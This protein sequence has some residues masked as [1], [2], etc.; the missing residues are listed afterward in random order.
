MPKE[1][2]RSK[3]RDKPKEKKERSGD[4]D[5]KTVEDIQGMVT[6]WASI[7]FAI[8]VVLCAGSSLNLSAY[9][10]DLKDKLG[11]EPIHQ[12][13]IKWGVLFGYYGGILAGPMVDAFNT[14]PS[15]VLSAFVSCGGY[16]GLGF[17][18]ASDKVNTVNTIVI[19]SLIILVAFTSAVA[20][21]SAIA[22]VIKNFSRNVGSMIASIMITYYLV[23]PW[24]DFTI[25]HGY[26]EDVEVKVNMIAMGVITFVVYIL[27]SFI[28]DENEQS[29]LLKKASAITDRIG[30]L[31]YAAI[32][33]GFV[34]V[35]YLTCI[36]AEK[37]K[38]GVFL[39]ALF[40]LINFIALAF[41]ISAL[42]GQIGRGGTRNVDDEKLPPRKN[43]I[44]MFGDIR[45]YCLL[46]GTFIVVGTGTAFYVEAADLAV[47]MGKTP[48]LGAKV[49]KAY[50]LS[51]CATALGGGLIAA[52]FVRI[53][54]GWLFAAAAAFTGMVGFGMVF[55]GD[56]ADIWF[57]IAGFLIGGAVGGWWVI[58]PQIILDDAGPKSYE[59]LWG[60][61]LT[62]N[63]LGM[64]AFD[65]FF[66]LI[67]GKEEAGSPSSCK[68]TSC[69]MA[70]YL[71]F[72]GL[73]MIAGVLALVG[74]SNDE[75]TGGAGGE[76][77][78][79]RN[80]DA[81]SRKGR[82]SSK[83]TRGTKKERSSSKKSSGSRSKSKNRS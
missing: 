4:L 28:V 35:V 52:L 26:F 69:Y 2:S 64:F 25:R 6:K 73:C 15:F 54:N 20:T 39:I 12:E 18:T 80:N 74:L 53:I 67:N 33:G 51:K 41:T 76:R 55:L 8:V 82:S 77:R 75:G 70:P 45:Y 61:T 36:V 60:F 43:F 38:L 49:L 48:E 5:S 32:C 46:F 57:Y 59:T 9:F 71:V 63:V 65:Q 23:A 68:G 42:L 29:P 13:F 58:V 30:I 7:P 31:I 37:F 40:I 56:R 3:S 17:Y 34:A 47:A 66:N 24:F 50:W 1:R 11:F 79:L 10:L 22:T 81:N 72:A 27:A 83:D 62:M 78:S 21:I 16:I 14:T 19:V 44:Q